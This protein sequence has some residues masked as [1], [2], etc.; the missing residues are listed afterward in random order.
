MRFSY[1]VSQD[2][3]RKLLRSFFKTLRV[4]FQQIV[5]EQRWDDRPIAFYGDGLNYLRDALEET[6]PEFERASVATQSV[7]DE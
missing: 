3:D 7:N 4:S 1:D 6:Y 5:A 2:D